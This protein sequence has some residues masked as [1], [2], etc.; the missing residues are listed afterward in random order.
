MSHV[1]HPQRWWIIVL[2][3][4]WS[5]SPLSKVLLAMALFYCP[6]QSQKNIT[7]S[8]V[9][10]WYLPH[11]IHTAGRH[12]PLLHI[13]TDGVLRP[14]PTNASIPRYRVA[15]SRPQGYSNY[16]LAWCTS[17]SC[18]ETSQVEEMSWVRLTLSCRL[19]M[20]MTKLTPLR[21]P[22]ERD[23]FNYKRRTTPRDWQNIL[24]Q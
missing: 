14:F 20:C 18:R 4:M 9:L 13:Y 8:R 5:I 11:S 16:P 2:Y 1:L 6:A 12:W 3:L 10:I 22:H 15:V 19:V 17:K 7:A 21:M 23:G 24:R